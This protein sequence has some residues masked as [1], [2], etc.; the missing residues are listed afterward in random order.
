MGAPAPPPL[1]LHLGPVR[2]RTLEPSLAGHRAQELA[3]GAYAGRCL[4]V[5]AAV[6]DAVAEARGS[7]HR[8]GGDPRDGC[9]V[10]EQVEQGGGLIGRFPPCIGDP[11]GVGQ[12]LL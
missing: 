1:G 3:H 9:P 12:I 8:V 5:D 10:G 6:G 4:V 7:A 11:V 2:D